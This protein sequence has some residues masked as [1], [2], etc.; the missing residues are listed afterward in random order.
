MSRVAA[1]DLGTNSTRLLVADVEGERISDL[2]R[3]TTITRLGEGVDERRRLL[4]VPVTRVRN[5]LS[6][7]RKRVESLGAERTLLVATSAVRDA[8]NG[9]AFLGEIEWSYG[10]TTRLLTGHEEALFVFRGV[11]S[12]SPLEDNTVIVDIGGGSTELIAGGPDG[13]VHWHDSLDIGSVRLTERFLHSDPPTEKEL[14]GAA[15][16]TRALLAERVPDEVHS[17]TRSAIGVAGTIT[18]IGALA[19]GMDEYDRDRVHG[20]ELEAAALDEQL[21]RLASVP[22]AER[23]KLRPLDPER[24][25][26]IVA[27]AVIA[28]EVL[29]YFDLDSLKISERDILDGAALAAAELPEQEDGAAPPGAYTCC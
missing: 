24:A 19:I 9:E 21:Q 5:V 1:I 28:R 13:G 22:L 16:A 26:V 11:T 12:E 25:P 2:E 17:G 14:D 29:A 27:G 4:P 23:R 20:F 10:F 8:E 6:D 15:A 3:D 7:Y 18:S